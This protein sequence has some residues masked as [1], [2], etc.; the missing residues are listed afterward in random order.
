[1]I[2]SYRIE[3]LTNA[4]EGRRREITE[5]QINIDNF[6]LAIDKIKDDD[7]E[8]QSFKAHLQTLLQENIIEQRKS[9]IMLEVIE[10]QLT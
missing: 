6:R 3:T 5:Y 4:L 9:Q 10:Q 7:I 1:M 8:L 2:E